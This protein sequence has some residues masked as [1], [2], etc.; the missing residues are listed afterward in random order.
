MLGAAASP[1]Q[2][3]VV[4]GVRAA[5]DVVL[6]MLDV[7]LPMLF[8]IMGLFVAAQVGLRYLIKK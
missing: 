6:S 1:V 3:G 8:G 2:S 5:F 7:G 4:D